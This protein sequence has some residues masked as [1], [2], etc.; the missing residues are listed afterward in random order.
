MRPAQLQLFTNADSR[1]RR[2][3]GGSIRKGKRKL[4]RP[5]ST[6]QPLHLV[7]R[8]SRAKGRWSFLHSRNR[9]IILG[10]V[11][12][13]ADRYGIRVDRFENVGNHL[14]F[15]VQGKKRILIRSFFKV[16]PQR[17]M[18]SITGAKK[19]NP[20]GRFF[21]GIVYSRVVTSGREYNVLKSYLWKNALE[22]LGL[23]RITIE[24]WRA[25]AKSVP[26]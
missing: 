19:G 4:A 5:Y 6:M 18:F 8:S 24:E 12:E 21:D 14:H 20:V 16:L 1:N 17:I 9:G 23:D 7:M 13:T 11:A 22:A 26:L 15:I 3:H 25:S 2:E 10:L